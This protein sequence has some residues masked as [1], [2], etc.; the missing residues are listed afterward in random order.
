MVQCLRAV[1]A[2]ED[3]DIIQE[4]IIELEDWIIRN[5]MKFDSVK[6]EAVHLVTGNKNF[7]FKMELIS[8]K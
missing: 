4:E 5:G 2:I 6:W 1:S 8:G 3:W 7:H